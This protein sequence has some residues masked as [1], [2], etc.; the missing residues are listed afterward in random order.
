M[1]R[2]MGPSDL[3]AM[4]Q[5][6]TA[7]WDEPAQAARRAVLQFAGQENAYVAAEGDAV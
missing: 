3:A 6:W 2:L 5:L 7:Q 4:E 1:F